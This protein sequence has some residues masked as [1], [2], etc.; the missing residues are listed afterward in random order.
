[1]AGAG[2]IPGLGRIAIVAGDTPA[3]RVV[4]GGVRSLLTAVGRWVVEVEPDAELRG[5]AAVI[6]PR[7]RGWRAVRARYDGPLLVVD[8][9]LLDGRPDAAFAGLLGGAATSWVTVRDT[10]VLVPRPLPALAGPSLGD[11]PAGL[12][13][14]A[15]RDLGYVLPLLVSPAFRTIA[16]FW[17]L[18]RVLEE[19][20]AALTDATT[21]CYVEPWPRGH[22][23]ARALTCDLDDLDDDGVL[24]PLVASG[25]AATLFTCADTLDRLGVRARQLEVAAHGDVHRPFADARTNLERVDRMR[26]AFRAAG[27]EPTGFSPPNLV[28]TSALGPL[29]ERFAHVRIGYQERGFGFFP[30]AAAS[31]VLTG[32][33]YY[34]D[35]MHRYVGTEE[36]VRL[37]RGFCSWAASTSALAVPCFHPCLFPE[38]LRRWTETPAPAAW[39]ATLAE[40][41]SWWQ[42]R[43]QAFE[44]VA[45]TGEAAAPADVVVVHATPAER[46]AA[47]TPAHVAPAPAD[48]RRTARQVQ[49]AGHGYRVVPSAA[50]PAGNVE[51]P[52]GGAWRAVGWLPGTLRRRAARALL[53]VANKNGLHAAFYG[54]LGLAPDVVGG[55]LTLPI[56]AA[57]E[58]VMLAA[59]AARDL[60]RLVGGALRRLAPRPRGAE[61]VSHA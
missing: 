57:D 28:Y 35:F 20:V 23:A 48:R 32:V 6:L 40:V 50:E 37:L 52:L 25:G 49:V 38:P 8:A 15:D 26:A 44:A 55:A 47:L 16:G 58:P 56:V 2:G 54:D 9:D 19:A 60:R 1:V 46:L 18:A 51:V 24:A 17:S 34:P 39:D 33:S 41:A 10:R 11:V 5:H 22:R 42:R 3:A 14:R 27:H 53:P 36:Y 29:L 31:G 43:A 21:V 12:A 7:G 13:V 30:V 4:A 61:A 59:P 45:A